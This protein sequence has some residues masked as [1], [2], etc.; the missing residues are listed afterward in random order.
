MRSERTAPKKWR[1]ESLFLLH[2]NAPAHRS[3]YGQEFP[4]KGKCDDN[5]VSTPSPDLATADFLPV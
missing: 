3:C 2:D 1:T 4:S 5:G